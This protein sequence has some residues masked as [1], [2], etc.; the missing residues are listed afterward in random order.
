ME[1]SSSASI[2]QAKTWIG[3]CDATH[4]CRSDRLRGAK[5]EMPTRVIDVT[6]FEKDVC[7]RNGSDIDGF[8]EYIAESLLGRSADMKLSKENLEQFGEQI[9]WERLPKTFA[10]AVTVTRL[11]GIQYLWIDSLCIIQDSH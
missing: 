6:R 4:P 5:P 1:T 9:P 7:L 11:L 8:Q 10:D 3:Q 2:S